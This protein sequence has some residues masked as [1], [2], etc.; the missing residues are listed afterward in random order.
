MTEFRFRKLPGSV[1]NTKRYQQRVVAVL[2]TLRLLSL[3]ERLRFV[4][5]FVR[6]WPRNRRFLREHPD[7]VPP[8]AFAAYDAYNHVDW[9]TYQDTGMRQAEMLSD[10]ITAHLGRPPRRILDWG[11]G[12]GRV[13][14][15]MP[16]FLGG[17]VEYFGADYNTSSVSWNN[18]NLRGIEFSLNELDPPLEYPEGHF[19]CVYAVSVLTHL[20]ASSQRQWVREICRVL[21]PGGLFIASTH[22]DYSR[23]LD[24]SPREKRRYSAGGFVERAGIKEGKKWYS[25]YHN[26]RVVPDALF[27]ELEVCEHIPASADSLFSQDLWIVH[28]PT[29]NGG[30][31]Q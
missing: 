12:A 9:E 16:R 14:G 19:D 24:L 31:Q 7:F 1:K 11:C 3:A 6:S 15:Q 29:D 4:L 18:R 27:G 17:D 26:P 2:R 5:A 8:P 22:G 13:I 23:D 20:S 25:A 30:N 10:L 21:A 28:L